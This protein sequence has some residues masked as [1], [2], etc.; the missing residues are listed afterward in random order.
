MKNAILL[1]GSSGNPNVFWLPSIKNFLEKQGYQVWVPQL[2]KPE[3]PNLELQL[4]FVLKNGNYTGETIVIIGRSGE[5]KSVFLKHLIGLLQPDG[6]QVF[7]DGEDISMLREKDLYPARKKV[8]MVFQ[9]AALFDSLNVLENVGFYLFEHE[10][11]PKNQIRKRVEEDLKL[12]RLEGVLN[13]MPS[14]LS[15]GM[16]KRVGLARAIINRPKAILYDEPTTGLDPITADAI[17][18]LIVDLQKKL[19]ITSVVVTH[20]MTSA[21]KI[22]DRIAMLYMGKIIAIGTPEEIKQ[23]ENPYVSQFTRGQSRGPIKD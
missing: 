1:H 21:Y 2:P 8:R 6:G 11:L 5:G 17:N 15:G 16:K 3:A 19:K 10:K 20:D 22:A 14:E 7:L 12:V 4:P 23:T 9:G 18:E 13:K